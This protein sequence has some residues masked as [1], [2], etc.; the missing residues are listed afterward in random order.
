MEGRE[1]VQIG[2][3]IYIFPRLPFET[4]QQYF[5]RKNF[6]VKVSPTTQKKFLHAV[7]MSMV[8]ANITFL[9]SSYS[10]EV[11]ANLDKL[12]KTF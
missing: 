2:S 10:P 11:T 12:M 1:V 9:G 7:Q 5:S 3:K 8:W 6:L 4:D